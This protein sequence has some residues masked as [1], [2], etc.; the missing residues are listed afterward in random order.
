MTPQ[1]A[2]K[3][4]KKFFEHPMAQLH[5]YDGEEIPVYSVGALLGPTWSH[6]DTMEDAVK[7]M[8]EKQTSSDPYLENKGR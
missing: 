8:V 3:E 2:V 1:E 7:M 6:P 5:Y 4:A